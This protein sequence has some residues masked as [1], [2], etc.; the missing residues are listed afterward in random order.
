M[1]IKNF[2]LITLSL[3]SLVLLGCGKEQD[4]HTNTASSLSVDK[5][6]DADR[7]DSLPVAMRDAHASYVCRPGDAS[8]QSSALGAKDDAEA[9]WLQRNGYPSETEYRRLT[10]LS[11]DQLKRAADSGSLPAMVIYGETAS[12]SGDTK[13]GLS[14]I[15]SA[16]QKGSIYGYYGMSEVYAKSPGISDRIDAAAYLRVAYLLGDSKAATEIQKNFESL[17]ALESASIDRRASDL[18][19]SFAKSKPSAPRP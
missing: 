19:K 14:Y 1:M 2:N 5:G 13:Q 17:S 18:Y 8:C 3:F 6:F 12:K 15:Y 9:S 10:S 16:I 4:E 11:A 7:H